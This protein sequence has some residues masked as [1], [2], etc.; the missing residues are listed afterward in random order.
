MVMASDRLLR[1]PLPKV[2]VGL[3]RIGRDIVH[4]LG[5]RWVDRLRVIARPSQGLHHASMNMATLIDQK[6]PIWSHGEDGRRR[7]ELKSWQVVRVPSSS[8]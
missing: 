2:G 7:I 4:G 6:G 5:W 1:H 3:G 8:P